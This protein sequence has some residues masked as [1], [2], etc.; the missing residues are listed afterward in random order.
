MDSV[1]QAALG[2]AIGGA[3]L[4]RQAG[5]RAFA[6]GAGL[7]TLPDLDSF[8]PYG[9]PVADFTYHRGY[10]HALFLQTL[11]APLI[12]WPIRRLRRHKGESYA[13]WLL[14]TW[15]IL[16]THALLDAVTI[17]G[18]QLGLP[19]TDYPV[20]LGSLFIIDPLYTLALLVGIAVAVASPRRRHWNTLGLVLSC[21]YLA[22]AALAQQAVEQRAHAAVERAG[23]PV[24]RLLATPTP[25]NT[26]LWRVVAVGEGAHWEGFY[27]LGPGRAIDF[28]RY[29]RRPALLEGIEDAWAV[30]RLQYFTGGFYSVNE[31]G[32]DV[33]ITDLR[34]GQ[35]GF[36]AFAFRVGE[37]RGGVTR[38][39][40]DARYDYPRP[41][42]TT[43]LRDLYACARGRAVAVLAC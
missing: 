21:A 20:G 35:A 6:I 12:A 28:T 34:M 16:V 29:P 1:T 9:G 38:A 39:R 7:G 17:Y 26:I 4:G 2:A 25:F 10:T 15:L 3:V 42:L 43:A 27:T 14:A 31:H 18:T 19:F 33:V 13:R 41:A 11:A 40:G 8:I 30:E 22:G 32:G 23:L 37:H 36:Y 5:W 24:E